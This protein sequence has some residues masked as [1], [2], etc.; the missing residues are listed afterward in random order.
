MAGGVAI[1]GDSIMSEIREKLL[2]TDKHNVKVRFFGG[3]TIEDMDHI[4]PILKREQV[5]IILP[6]ETN[7]A[8]NLT[9]RDILDTHD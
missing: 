4:K 8:T 2:K 9:A 6:I 7:N 1:V 3:G 5:Y